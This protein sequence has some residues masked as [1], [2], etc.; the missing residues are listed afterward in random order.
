MSLAGSDVTSA[1]RMQQD[2]KPHLLAALPQPN[3]DSSCLNSPNM[4]RQE[5]IQYEVDYTCYCGV[6]LSFIPA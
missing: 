1:R 4:V 6:A 2:S 5:G 3:K